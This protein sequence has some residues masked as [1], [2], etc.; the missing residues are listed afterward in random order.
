MRI[1]I[2]GVN[3]INKDPSQNSRGWLKMGQI[4]RLERRKNQ[5]DRRKSTRDG[6]ILTLSVKKNQRRSTER[7]SKK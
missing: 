1:A 2:G 7:R 5:L 6:V 3:L 4:K